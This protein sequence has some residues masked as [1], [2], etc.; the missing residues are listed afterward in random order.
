MRF[1]LS[2]PTG[3][4][5]GRLAADGAP[6]DSGQHG[7]L[8]ETVIVPDGRTD[9]EKLREL[10]GNPEETHLDL[11]ASVDLKKLE[12][13]LKFVKDVVTMSNRPPGG[14]LVRELLTDDYDGLPPDQLFKRSYVDRCNLVHGSVNRPTAATLEA[15]NP[16][17]T[18]F[19]T[20]LLDAAIFR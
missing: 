10:L 5:G 14:A 12:D 20:D 9:Y 3:R 2:R 18:R 4:H 15:R 6:R 7:R 19:V 17:L 11:K 1:K 8:G 13:R 16:I